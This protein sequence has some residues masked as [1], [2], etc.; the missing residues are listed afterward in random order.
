MATA[1]E[2]IVALKERLAQQET[3]L[4]FLS[5]MVVELYAAVD[6]DGGFNG[7]ARSFAGAL[8]RPVMAL[9]PNDVAVKMVASGA[10]PTEALAVV[11]RE[12]PKF[13]RVIEAAGS[14]TKLLR[15]EVTWTDIGL[16]VA[17]RMEN[18]HGR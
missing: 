11:A 12:I 10:S 18:K 2:E 16:T 6:G 1:D 3:M 13:A 7:K 9:V 14:V 17:S 15:A 8:L 5:A 4:R